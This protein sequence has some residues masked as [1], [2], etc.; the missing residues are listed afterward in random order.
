MIYEK[1]DLYKYFNIERKGATDGY[2]TA[3]C[4][5][6]TTELGL[7]KRP[8]MLIMPGGGYWFVSDREGEPVALK[9]LQAGYSA[10]VLEYT[11]RTKFPVPLIEACMAA[12]YIRENAAKYFVDEEHIAAIGF[13]A[14]A[15]LAGM[16]GNLYC[17]PEIKSVLKQKSELAKISALV[18]SYPVVSMTEFA[19]EGSRDILTG[20]D[21][22]LYE[23]LSLEKRITKD[24]PP[25]FIWHTVADDCV[26]AENS[27]MLA[28]AYKAAKVPFTLHLFEDGWHG[29][30]LCDNETN[31]L[32][33]ELP[34]IY[35]AGKWFEL[36]LDWLSEHGFNVRKIGDKL[37]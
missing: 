7:K 9:Y 34:H 13:S 6:G 32:S 20:K 29:L 33:E 10:F 21:E 35:H 16:L 30:C 28:R 5:E 4:R 17:E 24:S 36:S 1:I 27:L 8:A 14:G 26:P 11:V 31:D 23:R 25:A 18:L 12:V 3:Y 19:H 2:L 22:S 37:C 15:H